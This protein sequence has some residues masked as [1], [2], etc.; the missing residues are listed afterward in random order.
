MS[1]SL[2][3]AVPPAQPAGGVRIPAGRWTAGDAVD[4]VIGQS[5]VSSP[6]SCQTTHR[7]RSVTKV[8]INAFLALLYAIVTNRRKP[9]I[10]I[11]RHISTTGWGRVGVDR[12]VPSRKT[13]S[14]KIVHEHSA[15]SW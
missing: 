6:L 1:V 5:F 7:L 9:C 13:L 12:L 10:W 11:A 3:V 15:P 4:S 2:V 14:E 8:L